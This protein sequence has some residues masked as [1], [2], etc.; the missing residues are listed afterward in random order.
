MRFSAIS[1]DMIDI[2]QGISGYGIYV[3]E[4]ELEDV[5]SQLEM[6]QGMFRAL[7]FVI[8]LNFAFFPGYQ[9]V[10]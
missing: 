10:Y 5:T 6:S 4:K 1:I 3:K 2:M 9:F 7:S 8:L